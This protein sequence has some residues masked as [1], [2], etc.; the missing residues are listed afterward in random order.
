MVIAG[1]RARA[2][3]L[4]VPHMTPA[5]GWTGLR[6]TAAA[7]IPGAEQNSQVF[8]TA[9][10]VVLAAQAE[11]ASWAT[12]TVDP[13]PQQARLPRVAQTRPICQRLGP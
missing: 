5:F 10:S 9:D 1:R 12:R 11:S 7:A 6:R 8:Q 3:L 2:K 13:K 4:V